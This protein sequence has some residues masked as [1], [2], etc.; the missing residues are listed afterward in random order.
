M[1]ELTLADVQ[2][3]SATQ[4]D[5]AQIEAVARIRSL[6]G[7]R[8]TRA[9]FRREHERLWGIPQLFAAV[10]FAMAAVVSSI[11]IAQR[12]ATVSGDVGGWYTIAHQV[13]YIFMAELAMITF[14]VMFG[15][16]RRNGGFTQNWRRYVYA[17]LALAAAV[18]VVRANWLGWQYWLESIMPP[19]FTIG[20]GFMLEHILIRTVMRERE[21]TAR[22][23]QATDEH[24]RAQTDP[25]T[26]PAYQ[27]V[28]RESVFDAIVKAQRGRGKTERINFIHDLAGPD[29]LRLVM[30]ELQAMRWAELDP[31]ALPEVT[32][33]AP[34]GASLP[35]NLNG[36]GHHL[37]PVTVN[38]NH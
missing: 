26:H 35:A 21:I 8:P 30:S 17:A 1:T 38:G 18:F 7:G 24:E 11:H 19:A 14:L 29:K 28:L 13:T 27:R 25:E 6:A 32:T 15:V 3:L 12:M 31:A 16:T 34:K 10:I 5:E 20:T 22:Y 33:P 9:Q 37:E 2:P 36:N 23:A 4:R